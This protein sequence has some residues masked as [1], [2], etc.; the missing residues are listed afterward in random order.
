MRYTRFIAPA[1]GLVVL[2]CLSVGWQFRKPELPAKATKK[3]HSFESRTEVLD[4]LQ[5][6]TRMAAF[7]DKD[8][9]DGAYMHAWQD[10]QRLFHPLHNSLS[11]PAPWKNRGP[12]NIGGRTISIAIDPVDTALVFLGSASG[13]LW[14]S[15]HGGIGVNAWTYVPTGF[16][17]LGVGAIAISPANHTTLFIGTGETYAYSNTDLGLVD[18]TTR[19]TFG[20]GI[21][22]STDGG[23][24]WTQVLNWSYNQKHSVWDIVFNPKNPNTMYAATTEGVYKST[25]GGTTWNSVWAVQM[26][27][28]LEVNKNDTSTLFCGVGNLSSTVKGLYRTTNGGATWSVLSSGLP[29]ATNNGR[30]SVSAYRSGDTLMTCISNAFNTIGYYQTYNRG[31]TWNMVS[32]YDA[33]QWQGWYAKGILYKNGHPDSLLFGGIDIYASGNKGSNITQISSMGGPITN[34]AHSD[35]HNIISNPKDNNK[36][37]VI[38]DGGLFR[39]NDF[40]NTFYD[41]NDGLVTTQIYIGDISQQDSTVMIGGMQ[42]NY[43]NTYLASPY[44]NNAIGGDGG[45]S[46]IDPTN[47]MIQYGS[48]E[49]MNIFQSTDRGVNFNNQIVTS[50]SSAN[51]GNPAAFLAPLALAHSNTSRL[52]TGGDSLLVSSDQGTTWNESGPAPLAGGMF[53]IALGV[54]ATNADSIYEATA[55]DPTHPSRVFRSGNAGAAVTDISAGLPNR[56]VRSINVNPKNSRE[57]YVTFSG[58]GTGHIFRSQNAGNTW[59]DISTTLPDMPVH[60]LLIDPQDPDYLYAGCDF[61][62]MASTDR[63]L[64]WT[65]FDTGFP[66]AVMIYDLKFSASN[67]NIVAFTHGHGAY[68]RKLQDTPMGICDYSLRA[69]HL[70]IYPVPASDMI[71]FSVPPDLPLTFRIFDLQGKLVMDWKIKCGDGLYGA[72][73]SKLSN[74]TYLAEVRTSTRILTSRFLVAH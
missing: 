58:F 6:F 4:A 51:L 2:A 65:A 73:I 18:R 72:D 68:T 71:H 20:I 70:D 54:S 63:G 36:V 74:G 60:C 16:P 1:L 12:N 46:I 61:G 26:A 56:Y 39:A 47:D 43:T 17:V 41:C 40:G 55:P 69:Q 35:I 8:I 49:Y 3:N 5:T 59:T 52:Y 67:R 9:P 27:M 7:P 57:V 15:T 48:Y 29:S 23:A 13:G 22:K 21:L 30:T 33:C 42:D 19:G 44:W 28:D 32:S 11:A 25:D 10:Y 37:Y 34:F 62:V 31:V 14:K 64:T 50:P 38:C 66:D 45:F 53:L 24:T